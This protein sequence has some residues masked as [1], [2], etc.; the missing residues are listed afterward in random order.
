MLTL[1]RRLIFC[2]PIAPDDTST[3]FFLLFLSSQSRYGPPRN[4]EYRVIVE[5]LSSRV[6]WQVCYFTLFSVFC[7]RFLWWRYCSSCGGGSVA[8]AGDGGVS[9]RILWWQTRILSSFSLF[10]LS[11]SLYFLNAPNNVRKQ[12]WLRLTGDHPLRTTPYGERDHTP[13]H[14]NTL[15]SAAV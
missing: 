12:T 14:G 11:L 10:S 6:S 5:N 8:I 3:V 15:S 13:A 4:T 7:L 2:D 1:R 9:P